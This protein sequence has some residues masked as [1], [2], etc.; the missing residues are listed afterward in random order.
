MSLSVFREGG[1]GAR[2]SSGP[3]SVPNTGVGHGHDREAGRRVDVPVRGRCAPLWR[4][5]TI[6]EFFHRSIFKRAAS[7]NSGAV[8]VVFIMD[9]PD[10]VADKF[11]FSS[12]LLLLQEDGRTISYIQKLFIYVNHRVESIWRNWIYR[13]R[14]SPVSRAS[15]NLSRALLLVSPRGQCVTGYQ[16]VRHRAQKKGREPLTGH[17]ISSCLSNL[18]PPTGVRHAAPR[19]RA[20]GPEEVGAATSRPRRDGQV[21]RVFLPRDRLKAFENT[22]LSHL[23]LPLVESRGTIPNPANLKYF[24]AYLLSLRVANQPDESW[25]DEILSEMFGTLCLFK[26]NEKD[27]L[28]KIDVFVSFL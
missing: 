23:P 19:G 20:R 26:V 25:W 1:G 28:I 22:D 7:W 24:P 21:H 3:E 5:L 12:N 16:K 2:S 10:E 27:W 11:F 4:A 13:R 17:Q 8:S 6:P 9:S 14:H 15:C 18:S